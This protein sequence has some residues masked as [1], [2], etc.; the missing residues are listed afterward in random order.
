[1]SVTSREGRQGE[2]SPIGMSSNIV[3]VVGPRP[4]W[5]ELAEQERRILGSK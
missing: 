1:V 5:G 4:K 2:R 3:R